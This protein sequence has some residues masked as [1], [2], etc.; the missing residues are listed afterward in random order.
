MTNEEIQSIMNSTFSGLAMFCRDLELD[1]NLIAKYQVDQIIMERG[2]TDVTHRIGGMSKN[3]RYLV[4]SSNGKDLSM[5]S[6]NPEFGHI[7]IKSGAFFKVLDIQKENG[8]TQILLLNIPEEGASLF[9]K[10]KI[11]IEDQVIEK[12]RAMFKESTLSEPIEELQLKDWVDRTAYP[13]GMN[14]E[15][16]FFLEMDSNTRATG[17][18]TNRPAGTP[19]DDSS[20]MQEK[21]K[22]EKKS[23][24]HRL[25]GK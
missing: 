13:L 1:E 17:D 8:K 24:W 14:E 21:S 10:S 4:A 20:T 16:S 5:L 9:S 25:F 19:E 11:N 23:F 2:F 3:C 15:G 12:A 7:L 6:P 18:D 22:T